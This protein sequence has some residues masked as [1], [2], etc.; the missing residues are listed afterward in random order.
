M[1]N[2][3]VPEVA[4]F[5]SEIFFGRRSRF[6]IIDHSV[7]YEEFVLKIYY[8]FEQFGY[9]I[10]QYVNEMMSALKN[11]KKFYD[12]GWDVHN[13]IVDNFEISCDYIRDTVWLIVKTF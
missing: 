1:C 7:D 11:R 12:A 3:F 13:V 4:P 9:L 6:T 5:V 8:D 2:D 10:D